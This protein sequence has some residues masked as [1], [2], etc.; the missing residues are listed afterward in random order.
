VSD[1]QANFCARDIFSLVRLVDQSYWWH[2]RFRA[3]QML[4]F[5]G[6]VLALAIEACADAPPATVRETPANKQEKGIMSVRKWIRGYLAVYSFLLFWLAS[7]PAKATT[8]DSCTG[9]NCGTTTGGQDCY[10]NACALN[11]PPAECGDGGSMICPI[12]TF[13]RGLMAECLICSHEGTNCM[14]ESDAGC[15]PQQLGTV[16]PAMPRGMLLLMGVFLAGIGGIITHSRT[17]RRST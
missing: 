4:V 1:E 17:L 8:V 16:V 15:A 3:A 5:R 9:F 13:S 10:C 2:E 14:C 6:L 7:S 12:D 11:P